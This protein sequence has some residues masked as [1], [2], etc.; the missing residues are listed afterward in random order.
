[1]L[2]FHAQAMGDRQLFSS[3]SVDVDLTRLGSEIMVEW[4]GNWWLGSDYN[5]MVIRSRGEVGRQLHAHQAQLLYSRYISHFWDARIGMRYDQKPL[6]GWLGVAAVDGLAPYGIETG[7]SLYLGGKQALTGEIEL[8]WP[9]QLTQKWVLEPYAD[10]SWSGREYIAADAGAGINLI[11]A[12]L[13]FR[14]EFN[15]H[16]ATYIDV[17]YATHTGST[18]SLKRVAGEDVER[19][20]VKIGL[21]LFNW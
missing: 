20:G 11:N 9:L 10:I 15:R 19:G 1:M 21:R 2:P 5:K 17:Y 16:I 6:P 12:G 14:Y 3:G 7:F 13:I 8:A 4:D 18:R